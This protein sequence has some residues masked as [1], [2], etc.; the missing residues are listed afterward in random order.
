M[1]QQDNLIANGCAPNGLDELF[2]VVNLPAVNLQDYITPAQ[3]GSVSGTSLNRIGDQDTLRGL[4]AK[5]FRQLRGYLLQQNTHPGTDDLAFFNQIPQD[6]LYS[7]G[8]DGKPDP[9]GLR[10]HGRINPDYFSL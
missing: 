3:P 6:T 2:Y 7:S 8:R 9:L 4:E 5:V 10:I 1:D